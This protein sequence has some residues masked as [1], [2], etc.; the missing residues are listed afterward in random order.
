MA[1]ADES[2]SAVVVGASFIGLEVAASLR[3]RGLE[4]AVVAPEEV[5]FAPILGPDLGSFIRSLHE[6]EGVRFFLERTV[7]EIRERGVVLED[8]TELAA[9]LVV[10]GI[11]AE[12]KGDC[13]EGGCSVAFRKDGELVALGT[14]FQDRLSLETEAEL[15]SGGGAEVRA[16]GVDD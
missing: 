12:K 15:E 10:V 11:G 6:E 5:P 7:R 14:V 2:K 1:R 16:F 8:G 3:S 9:D 13:K 4:V